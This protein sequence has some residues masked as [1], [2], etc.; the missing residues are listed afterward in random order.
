M[1]DYIAFDTS[2]YTTSVAVLKAGKLYSERRLLQVE[3]GERG[4]R[5]SDAVFLHT[6]ALHEITEIVMKQ[7]GGA[8]ISAIGYS[9]RPR[10]VDGSYMPCFLV[11]ENAAKTLAS[12]LGVPAYAFSH[13]EGH[14]RAGVY[15]CGAPKAFNNEF[16]F[17][18]VSGGTTELLRVTPTGVGYAAEIVAE[19]GDISVGQLVDRTGVLLGMGFPAGGELEEAAKKFD[20]KP[21]DNLR[22]KP[23]F[24]DGTLN[25]SGFENKVKT[26]IEKGVSKDEIAFAAL[27]FSADA[28]IAATEYAKEKYGD[29][30][31]LFAG[32]VMRN[33]YIRSR[34]EADKA[35]FASIEFSSDNAAGTVLLTRDRHLNGDK[36]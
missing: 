2:N 36:L 20:G 12:V 3:K 25:L 14:I 7:C 32:G 1:A 5:Q 26:A 15:S 13:Q 17:F 19:T 34:L 10:N 27:H 22:I 35:F 23:V 18:H 6:K 33:E 29:L 9:N 28:L 16:L 21:N 8:D 30:P 24:R 31:V 4:L 11:G